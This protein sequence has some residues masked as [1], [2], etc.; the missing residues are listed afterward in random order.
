[1]RFQ[2]GLRDLIFMVIVAA[3]VF[4]WTIDRYRLMAEVGRLNAELTSIELGWKA[5]FVMRDRLDQPRR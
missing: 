4:G 2:F 5:Q 3:V 1:M